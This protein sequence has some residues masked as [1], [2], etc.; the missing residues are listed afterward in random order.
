[1]KYHTPIEYWFPTNYEW[2]I[3][4]MLITCIIPEKVLHNKW[5]QM[6]P[7]V[8]A[9]FVISFYDSTESR[10]W[11]TECDSE[12]NSKLQKLLHFLTNIQRI[13][14]DWDRIDTIR[15]YFLRLIWRNLIFISSHCTNANKEAS[16]HMWIY[17]YVAIVTVKIMQCL[18]R[19]NE[20]CIRSSRKML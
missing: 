3:R 17:V 2:V 16:R 20:K 6:Y 12:H 19:F 9:M 1:M 13:W 7:N 18:W 4:K 10:G 5:L 15:I 11:D 8:A 14:C